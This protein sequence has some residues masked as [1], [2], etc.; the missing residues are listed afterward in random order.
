M[1]AA[2]DWGEEGR[3]AMRKVLED[4]LL[5][6]LLMRSN[7]TR[8]QFET[9]FVDQLGPDLANKSLTKEEMTELR[10]LGRK[11]SRGAFN[12]TLRQA[13]SNIAESI[14]TILLLGYSG[15]LDS[16]SLAPFIEASERLR[17][18]MGR[19]KEPLTD[20]VLYRDLIESI[21]HD[22]DEATDALRGRR[23]GV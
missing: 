7:L 21:L 17:G 14:Y 16:P 12:R 20:S 6:T 15:L 13:H 19:F 10:H 9:I 3:S 23:R 11:I 2:L 22:L 4:R 18:Q 1:T 8:T 5:S